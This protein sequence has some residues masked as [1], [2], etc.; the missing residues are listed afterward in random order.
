MF[1]IAHDLV[2][3]NKKKIVLYV[4]PILTSLTEKHSRLPLSFIFCFFV[5][6]SFCL[7]I[8]DADWICMAHNAFVLF[9][10]KKK[11]E[12]SESRLRIILFRS[13]KP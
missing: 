10:L 4:S 8:D 11:K 12:E 1:R 13:R 6:L 9:P 5:E 3:K 2:I 7:L